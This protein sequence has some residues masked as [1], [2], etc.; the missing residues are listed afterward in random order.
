MSEEFR[1]KL[2]N[3][4][5]SG[6]RT[7]VAGNFFAPFFDVAFY[8]P[9]KE[10]GVIQSSGDPNEVTTYVETE[11]GRQF[12]ND[13][14]AAKALLDFGARGAIDTS[15]LRLRSE[16]GQS[17]LLDPNTE[18][19][20]IRNFRSSLTINSLESSNV[21]AILTLQPPY[22]DALEIIDNTLI[23]LGS[24][25]VIQWGYL[26]ADGGEPIL[27]SKGLF[28]MTEPSVKFGE[29]VTIEI[30]GYDVTYMGTSSLDRRCSWPREQFKTDLDVVRTVIK[31]S[32]GDTL[33]IDDTGVKE[34]SPL[35]VEQTSNP[36]I[37][38]DDDFSF[39]RKVLKFNDVG[40]RV[41]GDRLLLFDYSTV[42]SRDP[43]YTLMMYR[44]PEKATDIPM[45]SFS[46]NSDLG[47]F[48]NSK[49]SRG[50][51]VYSHDLDNNT[52]LRR[53][54]KPDDTGVA[55]VHAGR[56]T[57]GEASHPKETT[58]TQMGQARAYDFPDSECASGWIQVQPTERPSQ[59]A[60]ADTQARV[61]RRA[62][63]SANVV[64]P[65]HPG[66]KPLTIVEVFGDKLAGVGWKFGGNYRIMGVTH[67]IGSGGYI[68]K[69]D[70]LRAGSSGDERDYG[71]PSQDPKNTKSADGSSGETVGPKLAEESSADVDPSTQ[72]GNEGFFATPGS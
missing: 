1:A 25:M 14:A 8:R 38:T 50:L 52:P 13:F 10:G 69:F 36:W 12:S 55:Q 65:G 40:Y 11:D 26:N 2:E 23:R 21:Q 5:Q 28:T 51:W 46:A 3:P 67:E 53:E 39:F 62:N 41:D 20:Q 59:K 61:I 71:N 45:I 34:D 56:V 60:Y 49:G 19:S 43:K 33:E 7:D 63:H 17:Q 54:V 37:Q 64:I 31:K 44:Q 18:L 30:P 24:Y 68:T 48:S 66:I 16:N 47:L 58:D 35:R 42:D 22:A 72:P 70:L 27:S 4:Q 6:D 15:S 57:T 9:S 32:I 29:Q